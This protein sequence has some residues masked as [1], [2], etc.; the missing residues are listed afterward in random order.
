[1]HLDCTLLIKNNYV[2][3][4][5]EQ[6]LGQENQDSQQMLNQ[7]K[8][9]FSLTYFKITSRAIYAMQSGSQGKGLSLSEK[10]SH[11]EMNSRTIY[12]L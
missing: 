6:H 7:P 11:V 12:V 3:P 5:Q 2:R 4:G 8:G 10:V 1:M 9:S